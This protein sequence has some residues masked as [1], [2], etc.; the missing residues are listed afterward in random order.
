MKTRTITLT[1]AMLICIAGY[2]VQWKSYKN[3]WVSF[4]YPENTQ[5]TF[6]PGNG[7]SFT[8]N[9]VYGIDEADENGDINAFGI[10][11][12]YTEL[13]DKMPQEQENIDKDYE[14][15]VNTFKQQLYESFSDS[16]T[17]VAIGEANIGREGGHVNLIEIP[18][19][20]NGSNEYEHLE[21]KVAMHIGSKDVKVELYFYNNEYSK[22]L[23]MRCKSSIIVKM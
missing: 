22:E 6:D 3:Q 2:A 23:L 11:F 13:G 10:M 8:L 16:T 21:G 19:E 17:Y 1:L 15:L 12:Q 20:L 5:H 18:Y 14:S 9:I 7:N 4:E